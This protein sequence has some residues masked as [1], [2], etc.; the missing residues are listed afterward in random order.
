M[1][2]SHFFILMP[3][4]ITPLGKEF[5]KKKNTYIGQAGEILTGSINY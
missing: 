1:K 4:I 3:P 2:T 5:K